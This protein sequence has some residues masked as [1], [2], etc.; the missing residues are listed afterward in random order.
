MALHEFK[1]IEN[2]T[3]STKSVPYQFVEK[4]QI[5]YLNDEDLEMYANCAW[6]LPRNKADAIPEKPVMSNLVNASRGLSG[7]EAMSQLTTPAVNPDIVASDAVYQATADAL[8]DAQVSTVKKPKVKAVVE[9]EPFE[10]ETTGG[11]QV[12][13]GN[14]DAI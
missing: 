10:D 5:V 14:Q 9:A 13:T 8:A 4:D 11:D 3:I 6:L 1:A 2:G 12:G 7:I